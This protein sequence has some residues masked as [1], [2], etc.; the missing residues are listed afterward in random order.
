MTLQTRGSAAIN[1]AQ[2]RLASLKSI[3]ENLDLGH[4]LTIDVY[5]QMIETVRSAI[6]AH[7][8]LVS[9][10]DES[11]RNVTV[12]ERELADLSTRMLSGVST[13]YGRNSNEYRKAGGSLRKGKTATAP[14]IAST[15]SE[16]S[17]SAVSI[18]NSTNG[19]GQSQ[20]QAV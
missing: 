3:D 16:S 12:L 5:A 8:T 15:T 11:R 13:K 18:I 19:T 20:T 17:Q 7:N 9:K 14:L 10:I 1:K 2:R 6:E 4:G